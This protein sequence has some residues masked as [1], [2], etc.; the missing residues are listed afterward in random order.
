MKSLVLPGRLVFGAFLLANGISHF[1]HPL[2]SLPAGSEPLAIQL[3][4]A[5]VHSRLIDVA[6]AIELAA[7]ALLLAGWLVP[8]A[9]CAVMPVSTCAL[10][11]AVVL[12]HRPLGAVLAILVFALNGLL[13][14]AHLDRYADVLQRR[15]LTLGEAG[16]GHAQ[17]YES[18]FA[19]FGGRLARDPWLAAV[20]TLLA[21]VAFFL[22]L[23]KGR[24]AQWCVVVLLY[25]AF[26]LHARRLHD[27]G[28]SAGWLLMPALLLL[29]A[30]AIWL[31]Y[32][33]FG[34]TPDRV[35]PQVALAVVVAFIVWC[36]IGKRSLE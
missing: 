29:A 23:V 17:A 16:G 19:D 4:D 10:Y 24:T 18:R 1:F 26:I 34:A 36:G 27:M 22:Y 14:L 21:A 8:L 13:M 6:M 28:R 31:K 30:C 20:I 7:G 35:V 25:P 33:S 15:A 2:W 11:W 9:L 12:E 3:M 5:F 32:V